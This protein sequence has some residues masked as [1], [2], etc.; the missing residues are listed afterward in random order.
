MNPIGLFVFLAF[1]AAAC[2]L[3]VFLASA[4]HGGRGWYCLRCGLPIP[5]FAVI[6]AVGAIIRHTATA[7]LSFELV[8]GALVSLIRANVPTYVLLAAYLFCRSGRRRKKLLDRMQVQD[9]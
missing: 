6:A 4:R 2:V 8:W 9:L 5:A 1:M 7:P 3:E